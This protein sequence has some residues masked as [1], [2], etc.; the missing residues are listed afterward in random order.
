[1]EKDKYAFINRLKEITDIP[2]GT[3][4][5][6]TKIREEGSYGQE[7][8]DA[9]NLSVCLGKLKIIWIPSI[10]EK[11]EYALYERI[12]ESPCKFLSK[13]DVIINECP[14]CKKRYSKEEIYC[15][16]ISKKGKN[17]GQNIKLKKRVNNC[18][19]CQM[20]RGDFKS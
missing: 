13:E 10:E 8:R 6:I 12:D 14:K 9:F 3:K 18:D 17:K 19:T 7:Y 2:I 15:S 1:M 4:L 16:C 20:Y 5:T 11:Q